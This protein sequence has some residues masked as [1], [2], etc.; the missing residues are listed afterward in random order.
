[1]KKRTNFI[2]QECLVNLRERAE[3]VAETRRALEQARR[4]KGP[5]SPANDGGRRVDYALTV[6]RL[7]EKLANKK[8]KEVCW[9]NTNIKSSIKIKN[10]ITPQEEA[11]E[12]EISRTNEAKQRAEEQAAL[13]RE[14]EAAAKVKEEEAKV[15]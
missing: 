6:Q 15:S 4:S 2:C 10:K 7:Q 8:N 9:H 13:A 12:E 3:R 11:L 5:C 14:A 1:M